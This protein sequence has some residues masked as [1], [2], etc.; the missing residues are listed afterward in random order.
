MAVVYGDSPVGKLVNTRGLWVNQQIVIGYSWDIHETKN[1]QKLDDSFKNHH[2]NQKKE[3]H[4]VTITSPL[5]SGKL[6]Q[7]LKMAI[8]IVNLPIKNGD[9]P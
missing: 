5:P 2:P 1:D 9:F 3:H 6:T 7:L 8:E 4:K